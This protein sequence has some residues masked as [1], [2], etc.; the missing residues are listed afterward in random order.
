MR[1]LGK[2]APSRRA[3]TGGPHFAGRRFFPCHFVLIFFA[4]NMASVVILRDP[5]ANNDNVLHLLE[6]YMSHPELYNTTHPDYFKLNVRKQVVSSIA[7]QMD[8][9]CH[10]NNYFNADIVNKKYKS[11]RTE[12]MRR[13]KTFDNSKRT[14]S[15][16]D[17]VT[18]PKLFYYELLDSHLSKT[19]IRHGV[20]TKESL[21]L[22]NDNPP[23][24]NQPS[25]LSAMVSESPM[26]LKASPPASPSLSLLSP[27]WQEFYLPSHPSSRPS[28]RSSSPTSSMAKDLSMTESSNSTNLYSKKAPKRKRKV[29]TDSNSD[30][31][32]A[33]LSRL[34]D[35]KLEKSSRPRNQYSSFGEAVATSLNQ[36]EDPRKVHIAQC[37]ITSI[38]ARV[39]TDPNIYVT[40]NDLLLS[41]AQPN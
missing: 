20:D 31:L 40:F 33:K 38:I 1:R 27:C 12:Y 21:Y 5:L 2:S 26:A 23:T 10:L 37:L 7:K 9:Y 3:H 25:S 34:L 13:K 15:S 22:L 19:P 18:K 30:Q 8:E 14:G 32:K 41:I 6:L 24:S 16:A 39:S 11:C 36:I 4:T 17:A 29:L 35:I 28:S